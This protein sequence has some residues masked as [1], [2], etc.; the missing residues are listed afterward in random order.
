VTTRRNSGSSMVGTSEAAQG[1]LSGATSCSGKISDP[2]FLHDVSTLHSHIILVGLEV[3]AREAIASQEL[4]E[5]AFLSEDSRA[6]LGVLADKEATLRLACLAPPSVAGSR[7][8]SS[9]GFRVGTRQQPHGLSLP[10]IDARE[11]TLSDWSCQRPQ[12]HRPPLAS[13]RQASG[14][15]RSVLG[16]AGAD[17][18][19]GSYNTRG[20]SGAENT[21]TAHYAIDSDYTIIGGNRGEAVKAVPFPMPVNICTPSLPRFYPGSRPTEKSRYLFS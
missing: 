2:G 9:T 1:R 7:V 8:S 17:V 5:R 11:G 20:E 15:N 13:A 16:S 4:Y 19:V 6:L 18:I 21:G 10:R 14:G 12:S 3:E